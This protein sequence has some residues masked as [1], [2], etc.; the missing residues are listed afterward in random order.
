MDVNK[1]ISPSAAYMR[2]WTGSALVQVMACRI[3]G[4]KPLSK[5]MLG[6]CKTGTLR[7]KLQWNCNQIHNFSFTKMHLKISSAKWLPFWPG[8]DKLTGQLSLCHMTIGLMPQVLH[9]T[10]F[11]LQLLKLWTERQGKIGCL[12][13]V[14]LNDWLVGWTIDWLTD[15][16]SFLIS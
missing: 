8:G 14:A 2:Q 6:Y 12:H 5:P 7:N 1:H 16:L 10:I 11:E 13:K 4:A 15:W 3:F 9:R